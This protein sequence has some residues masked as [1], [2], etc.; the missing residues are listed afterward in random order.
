MCS[1]LRFKHL[2]PRAYH[3][4][5]NNQVKQ[6]D[7]IILAYFHHCFVEQQKDWHIFG[8]PQTY[9]YNA[10]IHRSTKQKPFSFALSRHPPGPTLLGS[11]SALPT[12]ANA[13]TSL[14]E[15][16]STLEARVRALRVKAKAS[17]E[18]AQR[19]YKQN[20]DYRVRMATTFQTG[21]WMIISKPP[22]Y[23]SIPLRCDP[24]RLKRIQ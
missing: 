9:A 19:R 5:T 14:Q 13:E 10:K 8:R 11:G 4:Q 24:N 18:T 22:F 6:F 2:T 20:F 1:V 12:K 21:V 16:R 23:G 3:R 15:L 7:E 17:L